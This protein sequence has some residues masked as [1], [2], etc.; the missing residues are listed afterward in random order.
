VASGW[1][2]AIGSDTGGSVR[3]PAALCGIT[4]LKTTYGLISLH[5]AVPLSST[6]DSIGPLAHTVDD[7]A[8]LTAAMAGP[9]PHDTATLGLPPIAWQEA[10]ARAPDLRGMR[11]ACLAREQF[12]GYIEPDVVRVRDEAIAVL[13]SLG[14]DLAEVRVPIDFD[15]VAARLGK[16]LAAEAYAFHRAYIED[17]ALDIDPWVRKR[18][19][20]GKAISAADYL[21][22]LA[23]M[24]RRGRS[25]PRGCTGTTRCSRQR[26]RSRPC[27]CR[28]STKGRRRWPPSRGAST[29]SARA[30][31]RYLRG[32]RPR[33]CRSA[34][35]SSA[36]RAPKPR[37]CASGAPF[38]ARLIGIGNGRRCESTE[39]TLTCGQGFS[40][41]RFPVRLKPDPQE[42]RTT[43][44][45][46]S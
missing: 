10:L 40:L 21:G 1:F 36:P 17:E 41:A 23:A 19:L 22:D 5:G 14:A 18:T 28:W 27:R 8:L 34:C 16:V 45:T 43:A 35:R 46:V 26:Y 37:W 9:D 20:G 30:D 24:R 32:F 25:S 3:I 6:L 39:H 13:R 12:P 38:K 2:R 42:R 33:A 31:C 11:I 4:G 29:I 7:V 44:A 15:D